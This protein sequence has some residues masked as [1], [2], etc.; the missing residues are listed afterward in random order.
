MPH[1]GVLAQ[2]HDKAALEVFEKD[3]LVY[4]GTCVSAKGVGKHGKPCFKYSIS[5]GATDS[6]ELNVGDLKLVPLGVGETANVSI[7]PSKG[8]DFGAGPGKRIE[9]EVRG[10][11]VGIILD[12]RGRPLALPED[13]KACRDAMT[14][15][16]AAV[17]MYPG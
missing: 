17:D 8:F 6:G 4:L 15:T 3:C 2:V 5:G 1:L 11:T 9:K 16:N 13:R 14:Q 10:G 12:A 7:E